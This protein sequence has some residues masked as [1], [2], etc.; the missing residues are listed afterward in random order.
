MRPFELMC[1][2]NVKQSAEQGRIPFQLRVDL[3]SCTLSIAS[4]VKMET[5]ME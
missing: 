5:Q 1:Y 3:V 2:T 4:K